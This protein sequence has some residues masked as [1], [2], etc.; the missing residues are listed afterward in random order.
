[1][2]GAEGCDGVERPRPKRDP[3]R[4]TPARRSAHADALSLLARRPRTSQELDQELERRGHGRE[5][6]DEARRRVESDGYL[7]DAALAL[8]FIG[9]RANRL[10]HGPARLIGDLLR[11]GVSPEVAERAWQIAVEQGEVDPADLLRRAVVRRLKGRAK[12]DSR[13]VARVYNALLRA[14]YDGLEVQRELEGYRA[15]VD[16]FTSNLDDGTTDDLP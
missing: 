1:V 14:G 12:L 10:G 6:I 11:R 5:A 16:P 3:D 4:T 13:A 2:S 15:A 9:A 8:H 7:D